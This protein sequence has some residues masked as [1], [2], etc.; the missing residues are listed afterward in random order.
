MDNEISNVNAQSG[1]VVKVI[2]PEDHMKMFK[3]RRNLIK[4]LEDRGYTEHEEQTENFDVFKDNFKT[5]DQLNIIAKNPDSKAF[6]TA[7]FSNDEKVGL[8]HIEEF[9]SRLKKHDVINGILVISGVAT[10]LCK[11]GISE[12]A[13]TGI[14]IEIFEERELIV[15]ITEHELVPKHI[16]LNPQEKH[17]LLSKYKLKENQLP[18]ILLVDPVSKYL[19]LKR[20]QVVKIIRP[21]ETAGK[22][23]TYRIAI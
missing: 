17:E 8:K 23:I 5:R 9:G 16:I 20:A 4:M 10:N 13:E 6:I 2:K 15:N 7:E 21:S 14:F 12:I 19:G 1:R 3:I 22:Y 18:K 11:Q